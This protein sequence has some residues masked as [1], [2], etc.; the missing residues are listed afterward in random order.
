MVGYVKYR[1]RRGW[2]RV[3]IRNVGGEGTVKS[4]E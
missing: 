4:E 1:K 3:L 2:G